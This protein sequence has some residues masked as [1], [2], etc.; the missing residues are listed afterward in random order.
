MYFT[1]LSSVFHS[2]NN[3]SYGPGFTN[4]TDPQLPVTV[5]NTEKSW[6]H[7]E[8]ETEKTVLRH[9]LKTECPPKIHMVKP[10]TQCD[11]IRKWGLWEVLS[12]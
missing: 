11:D 3:I 12:S 8:Q 4:H 2:E 5:A 1:D 6:T 10:N 9:M 7:S